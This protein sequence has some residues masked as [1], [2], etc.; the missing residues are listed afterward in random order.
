LFCLPCF[1]YAQD[2]PEDSQSGETD[3]NATW[4]KL[5]LSLS[6]LELTLL[7]LQN[8]N[9]LL[10]ETLSEQELLLNDSR[11]ASAAAWEQY[12]KSEAALQKSEHT[13]QCWKTACG[14]TIAVTVPTIA[15]LVVV[16]VNK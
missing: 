11:Q 9:A 6:E 10:T 13:L 3:I 16:L 4:Q 12:Q 8:D 15:V 5:D 1:F 2:L 7:R 14:I